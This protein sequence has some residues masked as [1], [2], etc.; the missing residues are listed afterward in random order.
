MVNICSHGIPAGDVGLRFVERPSLA[1]LM[2]QHVKVGDTIP[3]R[4]YQAIAEILAYIYELSGKSRAM[5]RATES[6]PALV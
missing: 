2:Y 6:E 3:E 5:R 1:R 4:F